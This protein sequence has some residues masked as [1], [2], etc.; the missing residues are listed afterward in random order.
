MISHVLCGLP[1]AITTR[2]AGSVAG[3]ILGLLMGAV[4][5]TASVGA[6]RS[7]ASCPPRLL[8]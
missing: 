6:A 8:P 5:V 7:G 1:R 2:L 3:V 4:L